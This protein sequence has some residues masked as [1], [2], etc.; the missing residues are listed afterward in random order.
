[1]KGISSPGGGIGRLVMNQMHEFEESGMMH[2]PMR[3]IEIGVMNEKHQRKYGKK[4]EPAHFVDAFIPQRMFSDVSVDNEDQWYQRK[5]GDRNNGV[6][7]LSEIIIPLWKS[8]LDLSILNRSPKQHIADQKGKPGN[9]KIPPADQ[10]QELRI[11]IQCNSF[12]R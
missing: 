9:E 3:P 8:L 5:N 2:E 10:L 6:A 7:N 11:L 12:E 1:M 4:I